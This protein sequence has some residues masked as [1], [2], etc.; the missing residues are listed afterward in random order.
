MQT[1]ICLPYTEHPVS[2][3][4]LNQMNSVQILIN[5]FFIIHLILYSHVNYVSQ[6]IY[7]V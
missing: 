5:Y 4:I 7:S 2:E 3:I 1:D 6:M